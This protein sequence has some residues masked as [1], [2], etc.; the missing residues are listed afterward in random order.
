MVLKPMSFEG[1][2]SVVWYDNWPIFFL[3]TLDYFM[4]WTLEY[5]LTYFQLGLQ[6]LVDCNN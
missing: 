2:K 4:V 5:N 1:H 3:S 6:R